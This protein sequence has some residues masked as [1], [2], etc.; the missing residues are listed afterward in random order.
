MGRC[1]GG[2]RGRAPPE[3]VG[4]QSNSECLGQ[5]LAYKPQLFGWESINRGARE[6]GTHVSVH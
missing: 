5:L 4:T 2:G 3:I 6:G 1:P